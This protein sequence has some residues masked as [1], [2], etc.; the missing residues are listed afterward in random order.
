MFHNGSNYDY[1]F[2]IKGL[3]EEFE[4]DFERLGENKEKYI[5]F[6]VPNKKESN[7]DGTI[8]YKIKFIDSFRFMSTSLSNL[9]DNLSSGTNN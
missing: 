3:A 4:G 8:I 9:V 5:L 1:H 6:S 2:I 7:K